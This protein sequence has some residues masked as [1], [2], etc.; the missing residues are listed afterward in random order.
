MYTQGVHLNTTYNN[1]NC[2]SEKKL[3]KPRLGAG[4]PPRRTAARTLWIRYLRFDLFFPTYEDRR[5][6]FDSWIG[7]TFLVDPRLKCAALDG[8][9]RPIGD[10]EGLSRLKSRAE[11]EA[12]GLV[13]RL[14]VRE[15]PGMAPE[16]THSGL[17]ARPASGLSRLSTSSARPPTRRRTATPA[18]SSRWGSAGRDLLP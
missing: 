12:T 13:R 11:K 4:H 14:R 1:A 10:R 2:S 5:H 3:E 16:R 15:I 6:A 8:D 9:L 17:L 18:G 7:A